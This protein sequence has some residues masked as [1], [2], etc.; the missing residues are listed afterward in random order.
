MAVVE[1]G[2]DIPLKKIRGRRCPGDGVP[3]SGPRSLYNLCRNGVEMWPVR[4]GA[5]SSSPNLL[6]I[7]G[8]E[9]YYNISSTTSTVD[10]AIAV[11][12]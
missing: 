8:F 7:D 9:V 2:A 11:S 3:A 10:L 5:L 12:V 4:A 6:V 1:I